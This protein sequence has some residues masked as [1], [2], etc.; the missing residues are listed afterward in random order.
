[1]LK[2]IAKS[3]FYL[4]MRQK[5]YWILKERIRIRASQRNDI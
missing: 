3:F 1:M 4:V 5:K 2:L